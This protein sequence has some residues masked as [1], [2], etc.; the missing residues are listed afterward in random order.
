LKGL[1]YTYD[2]LRFRDVYKWLEKFQEGFL[3]WIKTAKAGD[4]Y[5]TDSPTD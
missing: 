4:T 2:F 1:Y 3:K 5:N